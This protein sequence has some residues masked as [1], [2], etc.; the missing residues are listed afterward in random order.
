MPD[1][2]DDCR[3]PLSGITFR[4]SS[5][6]WIMLRE[7]AVVMVV[8][9]MTSSAVRY[10]W[11]IRRRQIEPATS[12]WIIFL[13]GTALSFITYMLAEDRD[14]E[15]GILNTM[16]VLEVSS[17]LVAV[18]IW[19]NPGG[20]RFS[21][22]EKWYLAGIGLIIVYGLVFGDAWGSNLFV[23]G[24]ITAGYIPSVFKVI[25]SRRNTE[26]FLA[27]TFSLFAG[28]FA[29]IPAFFDGN[30]LA[31]VYSVRTVVLVGSFLSLMAYFQFVYPSRRK[32]LEKS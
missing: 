14:F 31:I 3:G 11:Q 28:L 23:Q 21:R 5:M 22:F 20:V 24:L 26:S 15:T 9:L 27:W 18:L 8:L 16:D 17:I 29:L 2:P 25:T 30:T 1:V 10:I 12:T 4:S 6:V 19:A 32:N 7:F 13:A